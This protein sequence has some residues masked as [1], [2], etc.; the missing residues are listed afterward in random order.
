MRPV[1]RSSKDKTYDPYGKAKPDLVEELGDY[2]SYCGKQV[3][4]SA[5]EVEHIL[6]T[7]MIL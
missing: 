3:V 7:T 5:L 2:C 6:I 4:W 1:Y